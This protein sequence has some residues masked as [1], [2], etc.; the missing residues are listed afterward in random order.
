MK[1]R[2]PTQKTTGVVRKKRTIQQGLARGIPEE[3]E[4]VLHRSHEDDHA[5]DDPD[6]KAGLEVLQLPL[7][8]CRYRILPRVIGNPQI[9]VALIRD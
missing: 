2:L 7:A 9:L 4:P 5:E 1:N 8:G 3:G 6:P